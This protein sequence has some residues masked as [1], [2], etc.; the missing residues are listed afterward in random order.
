MGKSRL[1]GWD[2]AHALLDAIMASLAVVMLQTDRIFQQ[3]YRGRP[4]H[5]FL[6]FQEDDKEENIREGWRTECESACL[7]CEPAKA[8][9]E[10]H[11][12][13]RWRARRAL[14]LSSGARIT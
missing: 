2:L 3:T 5:T 12:Q 1:N 8:R 9:R 10:M 4:L 6:Q 14:G 7:G 11:G 13:R